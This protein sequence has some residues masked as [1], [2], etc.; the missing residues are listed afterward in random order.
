MQNIKNN[1]NKSCNICIIRPITTLG[2]K[3][4]KNARHLHEK[5]S[6]EELTLPQEQQYIVLIQTMYCLPFDNTLLKGLQ[7]IVIE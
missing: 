7:Y 4:H 3:M 1:V 6:Q 5:Y 2:W